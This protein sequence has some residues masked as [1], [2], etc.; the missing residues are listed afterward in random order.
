[1]LFRRREL[2]EVILLE[3]TFVS[4]EELDIG[5]AEVEDKK[6]DLSDP[7]EDDVE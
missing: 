1:M 3:V 6:G 5:G 2:V 4:R 7:L